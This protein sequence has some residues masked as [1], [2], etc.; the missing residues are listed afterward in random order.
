M[1]LGAQEISR[2]MMPS[3][4]NYEQNPTH[5]YQLKQERLQGLL[6]ANMQQI[7]QPQMQPQPQATTQ[8]GRW[9]NGK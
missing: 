2:D 9:N 3:Y 8:S 1:F 4:D 6:Q 7:Q 5:L